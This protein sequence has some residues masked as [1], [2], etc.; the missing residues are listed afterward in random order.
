MNLDDILITV[1]SSIFAFTA[2]F[3]LI[4]LCLILF[5]R[6][7]HY[8]NNFLILNICVNIITFCTC[9]TV[10]FQ[11]RS[12]RMSLFVC[13]LFDYCFGVA[14]MQIPFAF[15]TFTVHR[16]CSIY[17]HTKRFFKTKQWIILCI[18][19]QWIS[20]FI[21]GLIVLQEYSLVKKSF[22]DLNKIIFLFYI[23]L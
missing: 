11:I 16:F 1:Q 12:Q 9:F 7:F 18:A 22:L 15:V 2:F 4:Y 20:Q 21:C 3:A 13:V 10:Y 17:Y 8:A 19:V 5:N 23:E 6:R 14:S